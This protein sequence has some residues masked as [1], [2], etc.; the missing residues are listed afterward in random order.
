[1]PTDSQNVHRFSLVLKENSMTPERRAAISAGTLFIIATVTNV[2]GTTLSRSI[3]KSSNYLTRL[4]TSA[5]RISWGALLELVGAG[6]SLGIAVAIYPVVKSRSSALALGSVVF[7]TIEA[8]MY[9]LAV[10]GLLSVLA[11]SRSYPQASPTNQV[12]IQAA[13]DGLL[14]VREQAG[15]ASVLAFS[16]G[17]FM[18]YFVF[19]RARLIPRWLAGW[20]II[21][22]ALLVGAWSAALFNHRPI[23]DYTVLALPIGLQEM[24]LAI[25]LIVKGFEPA[26]H[27]RDLGGKMSSGG[28]ASGVDFGAEPDPIAEVDT[29]DAEDVYG[30]R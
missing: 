29:L 6:A 24:V 16:V 23:I 20:G 5:S 12:S 4:S 11:L 30:S 13:A 2:V 8:V 7:R 25:W 3:L 26:E 28:G 19:Y 9:G 22:L 15:L 14:A 18:Y 27:K 1:M 21:A 17:G 10:V